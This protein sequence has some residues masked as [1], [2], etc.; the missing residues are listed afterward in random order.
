MLKWI[1]EVIS[2]M[3]YAGIVFLMFIEN[4]FPP[5][6]S[7]LIVPLAGF[8]V[9]KGQLTFVGVVL[10]GTFGSVLGS[11]PLY[12]L[13]RTIKEER[14]RK[15]IDKYGR[16]LT[17][18]CEDVDRAKEWFDKHGGRTVFFCRLF[19]GFR[20]LI[21][22][23]AGMQRMNMISFLLSTTLGMALWT[24]VLTT[25]GYVLSSNFERVE[26]TLDPVSYVVIGVIVVIYVYRVFR[27]KSHS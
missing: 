17:I 21:S 15:W 16:W 10:A 26:E 25:A 6:P 23:P 9:T 12:Y 20:S 13:G 4:V 14:L 18:S 8:L 11:L 1:I 7:E 22:L 27:Q 19:P 3:G 24:T 5:I 2:A